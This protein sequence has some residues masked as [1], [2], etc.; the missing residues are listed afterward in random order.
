MDQV[1]TLRQQDLRCGT[2]HVL[3]GAPTQLLVN[4]PRIG[5]QPSGDAS[6]DNPRVCC[7][8]SQRQAR[9]A[10]LV[11]ISRHEREHAACRV[12]LRVP[13]KTVEP[14][15]IVLWL[16]RRRMTSEEILFIEQAKVPI[17][18]RRT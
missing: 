12:I 18:P 6:N 15:L 8:C 7:Q 2:D 11:P 5:P 3:P 13:Q 16:D 17:Y 9:L 10:Q 4:E 1:S 14:L